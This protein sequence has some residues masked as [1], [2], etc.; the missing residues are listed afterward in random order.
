MCWALI[1]A[2]QLVLLTTKAILQPPCILS[3][4][5]TGVADTVREEL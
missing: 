1:L 4:L 3:G 5:H 2:E